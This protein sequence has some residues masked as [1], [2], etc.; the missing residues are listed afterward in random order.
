MKLY[1]MGRLTIGTTLIENVRNHSSNDMVSRP[2]KDLESSETTV[3]KPKISENC[4]CIMFMYQF[5]EFFKVIN[6]TLS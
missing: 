3:W 2:P 4:K 1:S 6:A 5:S